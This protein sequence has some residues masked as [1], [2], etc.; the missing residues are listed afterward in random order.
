MWT[1][2]YCY[3]YQCGAADEY[4]GEQGNILP[5]A[6]LMFLREFDRTFGRSLAGMIWPRAGVTA[7]A[8]WTFQNVGNGAVEDHARWLAGFLQSQGV[9]SCPPG[10]GCD[11]LGSCG[12][13]YPVLRGENAPMRPA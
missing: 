5:I 2:K 11:E 10:C 7:A 8:L 1:D 9:S 13:V 12:K 4:W 3:V 6:S